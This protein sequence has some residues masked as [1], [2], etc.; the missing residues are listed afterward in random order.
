MTEILDRSW[1]RFPRPELAKRF[2]LQELVVRALAFESLSVNA[3]S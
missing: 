1:W 2:K 3:H